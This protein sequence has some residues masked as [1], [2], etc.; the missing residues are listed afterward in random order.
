MKLETTR[1]G[2]LDIDEQGIVT[3][4][5]PIIGFQEYRRFVVLPG[6]DGSDLQWL[7]STDSGDLA[8]IIMDP[9]TVVPEY[10]IKLGAHE[11]A[12]LAVDGVDKLEVYTLVVVPKDPTQIRTNLKAPV[13]INPVQRLGKQTILENSSYPVQF[14]L[15]PSQQ[16]GQ[17]SQEEA[18]DARSN[19]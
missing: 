3:F 4:T 6:P 14:L 8:F 11:L 12:E 7:Q 1:F 15:A 9:R 19:A 18:T 2:S 13:L 5:G 16:G 17:E 10:A